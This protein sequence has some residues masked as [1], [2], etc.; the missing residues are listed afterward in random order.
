MAFVMGAWTP[1]ASAAEHFFHVVR[2][3]T[4]TSR[5]VILTSETRSGPDSVPQ[6][7]QR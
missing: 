5:P 7:S 2:Q 1:M 6:L 4:T 3:N